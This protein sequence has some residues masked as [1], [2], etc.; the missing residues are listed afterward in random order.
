M[1]HAEY[2]NYQANVARFF[3]REG[4]QNLSEIDSGKESYF[5]WSMCDCCGSPLGGD[6]YDCSGYNPTTKEV[7][8][9]YRVCVDCIYYNV[10]GQL[11]DM[12]MLDM[13]E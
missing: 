13:T 6:R 8:E 12:T 4:L 9:V 10:Y 5:S 11:D 1:T 2:K 3:E 7:Q